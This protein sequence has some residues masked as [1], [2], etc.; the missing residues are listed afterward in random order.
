MKSV[1]V[2]EVFQCTRWNEFVRSPS[3]QVSFSTGFLRSCTA[4]WK[5]FSPVITVS[6][7]IVIYCFQISFSC[8]VITLQGIVDR[9]LILFRHH[10][11]S[12]QT[13]SC[14]QAAAWMSGRND[15]GFYPF[16]STL[17]GI[18]NLHHSAP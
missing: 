17:D 13:F 18:C 14:P 7:H 1:D 15:E 5:I 10:L 16:C 4:L 3:I 6:V 2:L 12:T 8:E 11:N 9:C